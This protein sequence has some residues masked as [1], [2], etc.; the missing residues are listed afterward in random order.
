MLTNP[1]SY[2]WHFFAGTRG[3]ITRALIVKALADRPY[4]ANQLSKLL[5]VDYKTVEYHLEI[6][7][8][9]GILQ[10]SGEK[11]T[12]KSIFFQTFQREN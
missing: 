3:R 11:N 8:K 9:N 12:V 10:T 1:S 6:L 2:L 5:S 7:V 4:N